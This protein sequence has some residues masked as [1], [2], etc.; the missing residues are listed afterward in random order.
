[1]SFAPEVAQISSAAGPIDAG[2]LL[3]T[4][5]TDEGK[6]GIGAQVLVLHVETTYEQGGE[7]FWVDAHV[8]WPDNSLTVT[9]A[10]EAEPHVDYNVQA[11]LV[12]IPLDKD[13]SR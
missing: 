12:H 13:V 6:L 7:D 5:M 8:T 9:V 4:A 11:H 1:M 3:L 10:N 2:E